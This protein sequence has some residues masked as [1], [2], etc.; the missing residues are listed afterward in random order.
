LFTET[1]PAAFCCSDLCECSSSTEFWRCSSASFKAA[2]FTQLSEILIV[3][4][5]RTATRFGTH[6]LQQQIAHGGPWLS[7]EFQIRDEP[8]ALGHK[9][10]AQ[11]SWLTTSTT[12]IEP[13]KVTRSR[14][15]TETHHLSLWK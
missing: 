7:H 6:Q 3:L 12:A 14:L 10:I 5:S 2:F 9:Q 8:L 15:I 13:I 11:A 4:P 1:L